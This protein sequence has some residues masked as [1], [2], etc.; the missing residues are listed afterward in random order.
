MFWVLCNLECPVGLSQKRI[1]AHLIEGMLAQF[2]QSA[3]KNSGA[4]SV[5]EIVGRK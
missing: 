3:K 1:C 2:G 5:F 4:R